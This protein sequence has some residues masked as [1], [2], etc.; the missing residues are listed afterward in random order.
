MQT[1]AGYIKMEKSNKIAKALVK[2]EKAR[3]NGKQWKRTDNK[4]NSNEH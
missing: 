4:R 1:N 2:P 3:H